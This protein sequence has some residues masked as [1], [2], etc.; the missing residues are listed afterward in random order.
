M[1][2]QDDIVYKAFNACYEAGINNPE[3]FII[4]KLPQVFNYLKGCF[5]RGIL[6]TDIDGVVEVNR[7]YLW[8]EFKTQNQLRNGAIPRG[9]MMCM[10]RLSQ[11]PTFTVFLIGTD[12]QGDPTCMEI[13]NPNG[14]RL[15]LEDVDGRDGLREKCKQWS[16][17]AEKGKRQ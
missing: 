8:L 14:K 13:I 5:P 7:N 6:P 15:P 3:G 9:Q 17:W 10:T 1:N 11:N 2:L 12:T 16:T 4:S